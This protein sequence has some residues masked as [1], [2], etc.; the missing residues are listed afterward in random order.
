[1]MRLPRLRLLAT[2]F[3]VLLLV[4]ALTALA[5]VGQW[6]A[7]LDRS[8]YDVLLRQH[9]LDYPDDVVIIA[10][11]E[12]SLDE[13]GAWPWPRDIHA[14]LLGQLQQADAVVFD[15]IFSEPSDRRRDTSARSGAPSA[16]AVFAKSIAL[17]RKVILPVFIDEQQYRGFLQEILPLPVLSN[18]ASALGHVH[19]NYSQDGLVRGVYLGEGLGQPYWQHI[20]L[21]TAK[22]LAE[23][24]ENFS[25]QEADQQLSP[26]Q[27]Y[28]SSY[29]NIRFIGPAGS[30]YRFSYAD[31]LNGSVG[32]SQLENKRVF[33][34]ASA[35]GLGDDVPTPMGLMPGVEF[36]ANAYQAIRQ[37]GYI[38]N[39]PSFY[40]AVLDVAVV[41]LICS[42]L[43]RLPP[44]P[45]L[46]ATTVFGFIWVILSVLVCLAASLWFSPFAVL[47]GV[48]VF[49]P[50]WS[51][52]RIEIALEF[53]RG[54][55][56]TLRESPIQANF[57]ID[58]LEIQL[59]GLAEIGLL[60]RYSLRKL[61]AEQ[62]YP[63]FFCDSGLLKTGFQV[64]DQDYTLE[65]EAAADQSE[66]IKANLASIAELLLADLLKAPSQPATSYEL[67]GQTIEEIYAIK[68]VAQQAQ[69]RMNKSMAN[70]QDAVV[71]I[72]ATAKVV[73]VND[74]GKA[75]FGNNLLDQSV[76]QLKQYFDAFAWLSILKQLMLQGA[77]VY[78]ELDMKSGK[79]LLCQAAP[80]AD[81][82]GTASALQL[83]V[84]TDVTQL[85]E[86]E[87]SKN[88]ALAFLSHDM[89]S[90]IVSQLS[91]I[92]SY[93]NKMLKNNY[94]PIVDQLANFAQLS[95]RY[96]DNFLQLSRAENLDQAQ[97]Q[98]IDMHSVVDGAYT[99]II[100][101]AERKHITLAV[102]RDNDECWVEGDA[103]LLERAIVNLLSNAIQ[104]S[105]NDTSVKLR[106]KRCSRILVEVVDEG[107]GIDPEVIPH[108]FE[109]YFRASEMPDA[110][111]KNADAHNPKASTHASNAGLGLSFVNTVVE[112]HGGEIV[113]KSQL[114]EG[115][116]FS[117]WLPIAETD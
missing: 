40:K 88:E 39:M 85:R 106:L 116:A 107:K 67:V 109:P 100:Q 71:I 15:I 61:T 102:E 26:Y 51:W 45:F 114:G 11:D 22:L 91:L 69:T 104:Y 7:S 89:R 103:N 55:L 112:R 13:I 78:Q 35:K 87:R 44:F 48:G 36:I 93:K 84:F 117:V 34:G 66:N 5:S 28:Q 98:L 60:K 33:I 82:A 58:S 62:H 59:Q 79:R 83:F 110:P 49:Y 56:K 77:N 2:P 54:E 31:V 57:S 17:N 115:S 25:L 29:K 30:I 74:R 8:F 4:A 14:K 52:R 20:A 27:V 111:D 12:A 99:Q 94:D 37:G 50:I 41:L 72:D 105:K 97:F 75:F 3:T 90:P 43:G 47:F 108:L 6:F 18:A 68:A 86:L 38:V 24:P 96:A 16:D 113:V 80:I 95:L 32:A 42:L 19:L 70:L 9:T 53:L 63:N 10:I 92:E 73:F 76:L 64:D 46:V 65:L 23:V 81:E 101:L 1:M 21:A